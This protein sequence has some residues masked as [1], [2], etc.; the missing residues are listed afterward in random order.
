MDML[1]QEGCH[2]ARLAQTCLTGSMLH[3]RSGSSRRSAAAAA[4]AMFLTCGPAQP[5]QSMKPDM[6]TWAVPQ[7][8]S[9]G[10]TERLHAAGQAS[11]VH[12]VQSGTNVASAGT[13]NEGNA[14]W[15][16]EVLAGAAGTRL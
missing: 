4:A 9:L 1:T 7:R 11:I 13:S 15:E 10:V 14:V 16:C 12:A 6:R 3:R 8:R 5:A 2:N